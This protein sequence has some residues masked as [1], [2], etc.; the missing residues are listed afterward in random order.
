V[1]RDQ[2]LVCG[3]HRFTG[4]QCAPHEL[5]GELAAA[6]QFHHDIGIGAQDVV[7]VLRPADRRRNPVDP[8]ALH[9]AVE[10]VRQLH[11]WQL[12]AAQNAGDRL[13]HRAKAEQRHARAAGRARCH[14]YVLRHGSLTLA[15]DHV[16]MLS[17]KPQP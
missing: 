1:V 17:P 9:V 15:H 12:A 10:D 2:L 4:I 6:H 13:T 16:V 14:R 3:D 11:L 7:R 5:V 8:L